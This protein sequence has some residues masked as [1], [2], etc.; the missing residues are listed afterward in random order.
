[1][2]VWRSLLLSLGTAVAMFFTW[3]YGIFSGGLDVEETCELVAGRPYD[4]AYRIE[5]VREYT[6]M[7]PLHNKCNASFDL[8]PGWVNPAIVLLALATVFL[9][10][11][12]MVG[13]VNH[14]KARLRR[15]SGGAVG[16]P[17]HNDDR[18]DDRAHHP[19]G[20]APDAGAF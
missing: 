4:E 2:R 12:A 14:I 11:R 6:R 17:P 8:V 18:A 5:H 1:M 7:F 10:G 16:A 19:P 13:T 20:P 9:L 3:V 15:N